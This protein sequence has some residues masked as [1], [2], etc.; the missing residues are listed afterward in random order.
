MSLSD[1]RQLLFY[2]LTA[3]LGFTVQDLRF[4]VFTDLDSLALHSGAARVER[5]RPIDLQGD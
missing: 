3:P 2:R 1:A 5:Q 4:R